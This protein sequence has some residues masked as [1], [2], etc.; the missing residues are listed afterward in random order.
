MKF[1][2][3]TVGL[4]AVGA[5]SLASAARA[6]EQKMSQ[7]QTAL[8]NTTLS[9]YV[10]FAAEFSPG[11]TGAAYS[12]GTT[13]TQANGFTLNAVDIALDKPMDETPWASGYHVEIE[14]GPNIPIGPIRQ[15]Y[16]ALRTPVGAGGI[17]WKVGYFDTIIGYES[18]SGPL[19]PNYTRSYGY[20]IEPTGHTGIIGTYKVCDALSI[21]AGVA[22]RTYFYG[23]TTAFNT[24][25]YSP[26]VLGSLTLTAPDS[27]G[28]FKGA[29]L[30]AGVVNTGGANGGANYY[31]GTTLPTPWT[32][33]K[34][35]TAF[36]YVD[37]HS[38]GFNPHNDSI[39]DLA[40]YSSFQVTDK[41]SINA[42][43]EYING[44]STGF[45]NGTPGNPA[46]PPAG[47]ANTFIYPNSDGYEL[48]LTVQYNLWANVLS[49]AE[50]RWDHASHGFPFA[51]PGTAEANAYLFALNLV[52]QF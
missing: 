11:N 43:G 46:F 23:N 16:L 48:T 40:L 49:R 12:Y 4:A 24:G 13:K 27:W 36:D 1:N 33:L 28:W 9:G 22:D 5:I 44:Q 26:T 17:D 7:V 3:W 25:L 21:T 39:W 47:G 37:E 45:S 10:D 8:S 18:N 6:D 32:A 15:A 19:N 29:S 51:S 52:Y 34:F 20:T 2:K 31:V 14:L 50:V 30:S 38:N 35:G 41:L 42:R